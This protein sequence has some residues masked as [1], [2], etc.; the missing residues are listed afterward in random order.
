MR[1]V[2][3]QAAALPP[4]SG[5]GGKPYVPD[6][7]EVL[8]ATSLVQAGRREA[9]TFTAPGDPGEYPYVCTFPGHW[10]RMNGTMVVVDDLDAWLANPT[11]PADPL[12]GDRAIV[13][14]WTPDDFDG[15]LAA[16]LLGRQPEIGRRIF[17]EA[18][19]V[20]CHRVGHE[21]GAIGPDLAD[22]L[23]RGRATSGPCSARSWSPR[24]R[25][26]RS[27]PSD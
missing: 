24:T 5:A 25:S 3:E 18:T 16:A 27:T 22:V 6:T 8:V 19:C 14:H 2:A 4:D 1:T 21:G 23:G 12:A 26:T 11:E 17:E 10:L 13:Q 7:P 9:L 20:Q 15:D